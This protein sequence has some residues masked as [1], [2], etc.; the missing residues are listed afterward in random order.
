MEGLWK[1][2]FISYTNDVICSN[3]KFTGFKPALGKSFE[4]LKISINRLALT[5]VAGFRSAFA[6]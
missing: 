1:Y 3:G 4:A 6:W 2:N 5:A